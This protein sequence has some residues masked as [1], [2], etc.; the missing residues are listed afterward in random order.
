MR[1]VLVSVCLILAAGG[2]GS[3]VTA[4]ENN[5]SEATEEGLEIQREGLRGTQGNVVLAIYTEKAAFESN[6]QPLALVSVPAKTRK[7]TLA[8]F[9]KERIAISA[10]HDTNRNGEYDMRGDV[11]LEGWG[12]SGDISIWSEPTFEAALT[13][14][15][16]VSVNMHYYN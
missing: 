8:D 11:P 14:I 16:V 12:N 5:P 1:N 3:E 7:I 10:F 2:C 6:G 9:P 13:D 4:A 15:G